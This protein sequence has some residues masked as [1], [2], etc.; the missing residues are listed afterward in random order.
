ML[1][2]CHSDTADGQRWS[3][4]GRLAG[5]WVEEFRSC[6]RQ[7][8]ERTP[9]AHAVVDL[10]DVTFI[11]IAGESLIAEMLG[12][13]AEFVASGVANKHLLENLKN[14][15][16]RV[17]PCEAEHTGGPCAEAVPVQKGGQLNET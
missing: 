14:H 16:G 5:P 7:A 8:M 17:V 12:A 9:L 6:W 4:C 15:E 11:D 10:R 3:L 2:I 13:G 1:R